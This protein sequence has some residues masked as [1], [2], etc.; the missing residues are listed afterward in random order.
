MNIMHDNAMEDL[1]I[2][3]HDNAN[4]FMSKKGPTLFYMP[5]TRCH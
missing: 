5:D 1:Q 4:D 2:V 3:G